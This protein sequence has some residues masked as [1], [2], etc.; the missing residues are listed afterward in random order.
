MNRHAYA[1]GPLRVENQTPALHQM[2]PLDRFSDR[3]ADYVKYRPSYP[4]GAIDRILQGL[5]RPVAADI[6]AGT[7]IASRLLA[8]RGVRVLA[9]EPNGA[10]RTAA[11]AYPLVEFRDGTAEATLLPDA[12]A[13]LVVCCQAF[14]W[15][16]PELCLPEFRRILKETGRLALMWY[17]LDR[18]DPFTRSYRESIR[19]ASSDHPA[20]KRVFSAAA[21][22][23]SPLFG[24]CRCHNFS[25]KQELDLGGLIGRTQSISYLPRTGTVYKQLVSDLQRLHGN[26][27][28]A[29]GMIY[30]LYRTMLYLA[31]PI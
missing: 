3:A 10:M 29:R 28:D 15:F 23:N 12:S 27:V 30:L 4:A 21:L 2:N 14:H 18:S 31:D 9:I 24:N 11:A 17:D 8:D 7:G 13:D 19:V 16:N 25:Y 26:W 20:E 5:D 1:I 6:G 22:L